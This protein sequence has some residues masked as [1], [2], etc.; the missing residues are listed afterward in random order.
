MAV[1]VP[2]QQQQ[3]AAALAA[4]M[5][6]QQRENNRR[7]MALAHNKEVLCQQANGGANFQA[8]SAGQPLTFNVTT[9]INAFLTGFWVRVNITLNMA[10][11]TA[12]LYALN[13]GAPLNL[14]DSVNVIYGGTQHNFRPYILKY[15]SQLRGSLAQGQPR[16]ILGGQVDA[17]LQSYYSS[18]PYTVAV[19]NNTWQF[20]FF[21]PMNL[22][23]P[24]D[25]RG[26]LP[27]QNGETNCQVVVNC[28]GGILGPDPELNVVAAT[29]GTGQA[30]TVNAG[31]QISVIAQYKD[32]QS[33]SQLQA[34]QPNMHGVETVQF[35]RDTPLNNLGSGQIFRNKCSFLHKIPWLICTVIDGNQSNKFAATSNIQYVE[36]SADAT[37]NRPFVRY[38]LNTNLDVREFYS[39]L[40]GVM[41]GLL[42]QDFDEGIFPFVYGPI[43]QQSD[44]GILEGMHYLDMTKDSGYTDWHYGFQLGSVGSVTGINPRVTCHV[45][46]LN[47]PLVV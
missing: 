41:G 28:A 31:S 43:F 15:L 44:A 21:V 33:Y 45:I 8:F 34:L 10:A 3:Q 42:E 29:T 20:A 4:Q 22:I 6:A 24:Q 11:G 40:S 27:V 7:F 14:I 18:A 5:A 1:A 12:A 35:Q 46:Y 32:G 9:G 47:D 39:D 19:G 36:T 38:G 25:V 37:G 16:S 23:H 26:I 17:Y 30:I 2:D 13:A